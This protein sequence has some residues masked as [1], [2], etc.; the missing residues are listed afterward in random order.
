MT[1]NTNQELV[2]K[3]FHRQ[4]LYEI[5]ILNICDI[6]SPDEHTDFTNWLKSKATGLGSGTHQDY[7]FDKIRK[8]SVEVLF[9]VELV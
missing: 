4:V 5:S 9:K 8:I 6:I 7:Y 1:N 2:N 3:T